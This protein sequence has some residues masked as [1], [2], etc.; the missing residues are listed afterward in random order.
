MRYGRWLV[1]AAFI[2]S[3]CRQSAAPPPERAGAPPAR[4]Q[5]SP[6]TA[7]PPASPSSPAV[8]SPSQSDGARR[9]A[10]TVFGRPGRASRP[11]P[12]GLVIGGDCPEVGA[13]ADE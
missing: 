1:V 7:R 5:T 8:A 4:T 11:L 6:G 13:D 12:A 9:V 10:D 3:A 2:L